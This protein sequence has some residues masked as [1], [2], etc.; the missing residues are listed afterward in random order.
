[1]SIWR[2]TK[3]GWNYSAQLTGIKLQVWR[4]EGSRATAGGKI[5]TAR[6]ILEKPNRQDYLKN[7]FG[8]ATF[9][10]I[11]FALQ[12]A[13]DVFETRHPNTYGKK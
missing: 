3:N 11:M 4:D 13:Q 1:M 2:A 8:D 7:I 6:Q 10:E 9:N 12:S 5:L